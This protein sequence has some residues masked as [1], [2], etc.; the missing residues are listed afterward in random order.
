[1]TLSEKA[2]QIAVLLIA[3]KYLRKRYLRE[4]F[5]DPD[6]MAEVEQKLKSVGLELSTNVYSDYVS[7]KV[8][9]EE[10]A[11]VFSD[12]Q[13]GYKATNC[14]LHRGALALLTII[15]A[16]IVLP[17]RQMQIERKPAS[18]NGQGSLLPGQK[19]IPKD[20]DMVVLDEKALLA[21]FGEKL[22]GKT[23]FYRY[24]SELVRADFVIKKE[25]K[26]FEGPLLDTIVDYGILAPR[27]I[28]GALGDILGIVQ[29]SQA[30]TPEGG[31][32][33]E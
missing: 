15:W 26:I 2:T 6:L 21:D 4:M 31:D 9:K 14:G 27:I 19:P 7:T 12:D 18:E 23:M 28:D 33:R 30:E 3:N 24:L 16:K 5:L 22:G 8:A 20:G 17:K 13:G 29:E 10:E 25:G 11:V 1:M 32:L